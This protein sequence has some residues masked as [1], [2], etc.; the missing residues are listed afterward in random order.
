MNQNDRLLDELR[1]SLPEYMAQKRMVVGRGKKLIRCINPQH[2]DS[3]PS[4]SYYPK[5][6]KLHC[7]GC[8][9]TYDL[10][11]VIRM[12]YPDCDSFPRQVKKACELFGVPFPEDFGRDPAASP[13][14]RAGARADAS[15]GAAPL[16][17]L[18]PAARISP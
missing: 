3:T 5:T 13:A 16:R 8:G 14:P 6:K 2:S 10:F 15:A 1:G 12:D 11:D 17:A 4:M 9:A 18:T 7:F